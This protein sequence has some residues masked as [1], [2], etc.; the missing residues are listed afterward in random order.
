MN[1]SGAEWVESSIKWFLFIKPEFGDFV[2][3]YSCKIVIVSYHTEWGKGEAHGT[4]S[5]GENKYP[6]I[7]IV[8]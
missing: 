4:V 7:T 8:I 3:I 2:L 1:Q 5:M 6:L